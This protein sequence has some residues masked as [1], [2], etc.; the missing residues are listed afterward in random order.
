THCGIEVS[1]PSVLHRRI[2]VLKSGA[3]S[4]HSILAE[5]ARGISCAS[6]PI[7]RKRFAGLFDGASKTARRSALDRV[8]VLVVEGVFVILVDPH[9]A[10]LMFEDEHVVCLLLVSC[11]YCAWA[12]IVERLY[13][14]CGLGPCTT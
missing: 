3:R 8:T 5:S 12:L 6:L 13:D 7:F 9:L 4:P 11:N 14:L 1:A 10:A 2:K